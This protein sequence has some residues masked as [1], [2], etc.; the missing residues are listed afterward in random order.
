[1]ARFHGD[2][3]RPDEADSDQPPRNLRR[4]PR[5]WVART[6][7]GLIAFVA[8][9][10]LLAGG[11]YLYLRHQ[12]GRIKRVPVPT[13]TE[14][15]PGKVMKVLLVGSDSRAN[16]TGDLAEE[17]ARPSRETAPVSATR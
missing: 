16:T 8:V 4:W 9:C 2:I 12:L 15:Q 17:T 10:V 1:M 6:F 7:K 5:R 3:T 13:L 11:G 14:D